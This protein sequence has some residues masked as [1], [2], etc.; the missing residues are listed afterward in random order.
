[1]KIKTFFQILLV[2]LVVIFAVL[3]FRSI[4]RPEKFKLVYESRQTEIVNRLIAIRNIEAVYKNEYKTYASD[5]DSLVDFVENGHVTIIKNIGN[6][7]EGMTE[8]EAYKQGLLRKEE[9][10]IP[11]KDKILETAPDIK[12]DNFQYIPFANKKFTIETGNISSKTYEIPVYRIVV[13]L[14][15]VLANL[16][17]SF[18]PSDVNPLKKFVNYL[19]YNGLAEETQYRSQYKDIIMGSLEEASTTGNWE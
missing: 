14:D 7:P 16:Q 2:V 6:I 15:D 4:M 19:F 9:V 10:Q 18:Q 11:A 1:M 5:I 13:P 17:E 8:T 12:L 3:A